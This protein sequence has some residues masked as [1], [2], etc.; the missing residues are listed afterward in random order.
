MI[1]YG[2]FSDFP[3][4]IDVVSFNSL[5]DSNEYHASFSIEGIPVSSD[6]MLFTNS[7]SGSFTNT[8]WNFGDGTSDSTNI[9]FH[10][11]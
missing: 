9:F 1:Y 11:F 8:L 7:S 5:I 2:N 3:I 10:Q 4:L 6:S